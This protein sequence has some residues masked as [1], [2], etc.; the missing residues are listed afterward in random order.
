MKNSIR[1]QH[2][3]LLRSVACL[4]VIYDHLIASE[5]DGGNYNSWVCV[6]FKSINNYI[7]KPLYIIQYGG[8]LGV[9]IFFIV[10]GYIIMHAS[11][12]ET[13]KQFLIKRF[14]R[15]YPPLIFSIMI[16]CL[17]KNYEIKD[18]LL[19]M[20]L[21]NYISVNSVIINGVAWSLFIEV[22][23]YVLVLVT[24]DKIR[25]HE[26]FI[27]SWL[28]MVFTIIQISRDF[29]D[30]G[31][32]LSI[33]I[34][35]LPFLF[36]GVVFYLFEGKA[37]SLSYF[38][39]YL[40]SCVLLEV[41]ALVKINTNFYINQPYMVSCVYAIAIFAIVLFTKDI[42]KTPKPLLMISNM[43]YSLYLNHGLIGHE[44]FFFLYNHYKVNYFG[45]LMVTL[46]VVFLCSYLFYIFIEK[47][48]IRVARRLC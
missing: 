18:I 21:L 48:F 29:G 30:V 38:I 37:I 23:F 43:S 34:S 12:R 7:F 40:I 45:S 24:P 31:F 11:T 16:I 39:F 42:F 14:F 32:L 26:F 19:S 25:N 44:V 41:F 17:F 2:I 3:D 20:T 35:Y 9:C 27:V 36:I 6:I 15:I 5:I 46:C 22:I 47:P 1:L 10:S 28:L 33:S 13:K 4:L 8:F